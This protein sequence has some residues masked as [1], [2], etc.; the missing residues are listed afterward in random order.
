MNVEQVAAHQMDFKINTMPRVINFGRYHAAADLSQTIKVQRLDPKARFPTRGSADC[1]GLDVYAA[2]EI[3]IE[4]LSTALVRTQL[5]MQFPRG[6][7]GLLTSRSKTSLSGC[8]IITG[9][10]DPDYGKEI[11]I[12]VFN[13]RK[14]AKITT[15]L[16][17]PIAQ[18]ITLPFAA[19]IPIEVSAFP[20]STSRRLAFNLTENKETEQI[21]E[22]TKNM[23]T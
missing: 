5:A 3:E 19:P 1:A 9:V 22:N 16:T 6:C 20:I 4:P 15:N 11:Y 7:F 10:L 14:D 18:I 21:T 23:Y 17:A 8:Y 12:Q 2:E 13:K